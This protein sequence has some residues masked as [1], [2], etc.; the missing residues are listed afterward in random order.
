[1]RGRLVPRLEAP[2][3]SGRGRLAG[4]GKCGP[5]PR[6]RAAL[7]GGSLDDTS[8]SPKRSKARA[9]RCSSHRLA[10]CASSSRCS[11]VSVAS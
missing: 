9:W 10:I 7:P 11:A 5:R 4:I 1:L 3:G 2:P 8:R 6:A